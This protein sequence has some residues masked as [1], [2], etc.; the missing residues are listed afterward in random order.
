[1][2]P[3]DN[4]TKEKEQENDK[5]EEK[6][7]EAPPPPEAKKTEEEKEH[8]IP[9]SRLDEEIK[10]RKESEKTL[11]AL[12]KEKASATEKHL[13]EQGK[14]KELAE[15]RATTIGEL[16]PKADM[17]ESYEKTVADILV[18]E[19]EA[20]PEAAREL[21]PSELSDQQQL[22]WIAKNKTNL[23]K[24]NAFDIGAGKRGSENGEI[25]VDLTAEEK[26]AA[27]NMNVSEKDY[28]KNKKIKE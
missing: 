7:K 14:Y 16:Q 9:K 12:E 17:V 5:L 24:P 25:I 1:M 23:S 18:A 13:E 11:A 27:K 19:I 21:V 28:A 2:P 6:G 22:N 15:D 4:D 26:Q 8:M 20:L 3:D 10:K